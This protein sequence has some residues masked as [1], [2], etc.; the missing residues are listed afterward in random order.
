MKFKK[1]ILLVIV[2]SIIFYSLFLIFSDFNKLSEQ[3]LDFKIEYLPIILPLV[4][5]GWLALYLRWVLLLK[6]YGYQFPHKKNFQIF[7]SGFPLSITPGKVGELLKCELLKENFEI[8]RK[9]TAP[10]ILVERLY[11]AVGIIII[12]IFG[13][14]FFDFS[15]IVILITTCILIS[16]FLVLR[17]KKF[18]LSVIKKTSKIKFLSRFSESFIDS[19][20][21][22]NK[23]IK[24]KIFITSS[25][26]SA[27][28]WILESLAVYFIL[29]SFGINLLEITDVILTYTTSIILG[30]ASFVPGGIGVSES[31]LIGLLT[32]NGLV[33]STA[34]SLTIFIRIFT[35]WYAVLVGLI[36]LK[37]TGIFSSTNSTEKNS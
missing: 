18:F 33:F 10:I 21:V 14:W 13:I 24:P 7:L 15:G 4:S 20:D 37:F 29:L 23:S 34:V 30:V 2:S 35:L 1:K 19:Y 31:T 32:I 5:V 22:I 28:Y 8:P 36:A 12:S 17:S 16:I 9:I 11:N 27:S 3:I 26:L 6:N 25:L